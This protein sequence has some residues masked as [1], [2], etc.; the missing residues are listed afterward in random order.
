[1]PI[2]HR[3][4]KPPKHN[5][6]QWT[7][8]NIEEVQ[9]VLNPN[10]FM[11]TQNFSGKLM[12]RDK[13]TGATSVSAIVGSWIVSDEYYGPETDEFGFSL[14]VFTDEDFNEQFPE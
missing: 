8:E 5:A 3:V 14:H 6:I 13:F 1:M 9:T 12:V 4:R 7:G 11:V 2:L 10:I